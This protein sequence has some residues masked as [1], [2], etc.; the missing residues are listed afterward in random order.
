VASGWF[1]LYST[2]V[3]TLILRDSV[4]PSQVLQVSDRSP[5]F[6]SMPVFLKKKKQE[7]TTKSPVEVLAFRARCEPENFRKKMQDNQSTMVV[8]FNT[9]RNLH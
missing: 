1:S 8:T 5:F 3:P 6:V 9:A 2:T 7:V 4:K